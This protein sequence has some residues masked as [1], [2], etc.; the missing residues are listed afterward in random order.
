MRVEQG[1]C[2]GLYPVLNVISQKHSIVTSRQIA[3]TIYLFSLFRI[4]FMLFFQFISL[5]YMQE[6]KKWNNFTKKP[7]FLAVFFYYIDDDADDYDDDCTIMYSKTIQFSCS[8]CM[9]PQKAE[10][11]FC[12][13]VQHLCDNV[14]AHYVLAFRTIC[15]Y[16]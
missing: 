12:N 16:I 1:T 7:F 14:S 10:H 5:Q 8:L 2:H 13:C 15:I 9:W 3:L 11:K 6:W 4:C